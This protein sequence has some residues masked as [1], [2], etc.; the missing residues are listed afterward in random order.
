MMT[1]VKFEK[2]AKVSSSFRW[3][4]KELDMSPAGSS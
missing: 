3:P 4:D 1:S 2:L